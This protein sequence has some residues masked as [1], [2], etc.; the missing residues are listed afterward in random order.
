MMPRVPEAVAAYLAVVQFSFALCWTVYVVYLPEL[1]RSAGLPPHWA[2]WLLA[3]DQAVFATMDLALGVAADRIR[4][5]W[6]VLAP[7]IVGLTLVSCVAF[8]ALPYA[9]SGSSAG[10]MLLMF[11]LGL[12]VVTA[13]ALRA[14]PWLL[15]A[16]FAAQPVLPLLS[17]INL[18]GLGI[19]A[20]LSPYLGL[21]LKGQD[22]R[23]PFVLASA[24]LAATVLGLVAAERHATRNAASGPPPAPRDAPSGEPAA[25]LF[26]AGLF[27]VGLILGSGFQAHVFFNA[28][29][30]YQR[31]GAQLQLEWLLPVFWIGFSFAMFPGAGLAT[32]FGLWRVLIGASAVAAVA[33][34]ACAAAQTLEMT[35]AAQLV[36]GGAWG[37]VTMASCSA[38]LRMGF[39]S[40]EGLA[41]GLLWSGLA[42]AALARF[43]IG[44]AELPKSTAF[45]DAVVWSPV[46]C[47]A[48]AAGLIAMLPRHARRD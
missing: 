3:I 36:A 7:Y 43:A 45:R 35:I 1:L 18:C 39:R 4:R 20:A 14:P 5:R 41:V 8:M 2:P 26:L 42:L 27:V 9:A 17:A 24:A 15:F 13:S 25:G 46:V 44:L 6:A 23:L 11:C 47:W 33:A 38:A 22:P 37:V 40:R 30:L 19:A 16:E 21:L 32:R 48:F 34:A 28:A 29:P 12:W 10:A 31:F